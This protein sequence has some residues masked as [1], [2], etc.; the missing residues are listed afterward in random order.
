MQTYG[1]NGEQNKQE[2]KLLTNNFEVKVENQ[3]VEGLIFYS[4]DTQIFEFVNYGIDREAWRVYID[5]QSIHSK[6]MIDAI[7]QYGFLCNNRKSKCDD[8]GK[9]Q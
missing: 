5:F 7:L 4:T 3:N 6:W 9:S 8:E 1:N 2:N